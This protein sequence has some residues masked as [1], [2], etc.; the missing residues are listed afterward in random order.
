MKRLNPD[1]LFKPQAYTQVVE[2]TRRRTIYV[3]GQ[4]SMD[5]QGNLVAPGDFRGQVRQV[6][7]NLRAALDA[8]GASPA[9]VTKMTTFV[10]DYKPE[11]RPIVGE[12]RTEFPGGS[13]PPAST[14]VG[15]T[16]LADPAY[17][18]EIEA[19]AVTE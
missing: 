9:D 15:V 1:T 6:F 8:A 4:V 7:T 2:S 5:A 18:V 13:P 3:S 16:A 12:A 10:V 11:L 19:I 14:L 17:L